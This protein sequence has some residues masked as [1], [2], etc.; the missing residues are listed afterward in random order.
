MGEFALGVVASVLAAIITYSTREFW[1]RFWH[2]AFSRF[3]PTVSG[4]YEVELGDKEHQKPWFPD[5]RQTLELHQYGKSVVGKF[6]IFEGKHL[7]VTYSVRGFLT[8]NK[9]GVL[10][11]ECTDRNLKGAGAFVLSIKGVGK[12]IA[13][14]TTYVCDL[15]DNIHEYPF[16]LKRIED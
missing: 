1:V 14:R 11:Y 7:R 3:Y 10:N 4:V 6:K 13:G 15:C 9:I 12:R 16:E 5:E 8:P 2:I